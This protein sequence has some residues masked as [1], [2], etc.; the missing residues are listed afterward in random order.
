[1]ESPAKAKTIEKYLGKAYKV[2]PSIGH[3]RDLPESALGVEVGNGFALEYVVNDDKTRVIHDIA[4]AAKKADSVFLATDYD[5]EGEAIAWH[6]AEACDIPADKRRRV[7]FT[8][9]TR[10]AVTEA[11]EHPRDIDI[12]L[13]DAQQARRAIDRLVGYPVSQLLWK[14]IRYGL[15][16]G[17]VQS[18]AL[19]LIVERER[20]IRAFVPVEYWTLA[21]ML[22]T[23]LPARRAESFTA[24]LVQIGD[25]KIPTKIGDSAAD[26]DRRLA[27][28]ADVASVVATLEGARYSV[29]DIRTKEQRR[30]PPPPFIT[31][32]YQQ[33]ASRKLNFGARRAMGVAQ[34]LYEGGYITYMRTDSTSMAAEALAEAAGLIKS[35]FGDRYWNGRY[36][37]HD[38]K[39][40]GAQEAHEC[41]RPTAMSRRRS[42]V[43]AE[44]RAEGGRDAEAMVKV[45][46]LVWKRTVA[47]LM[48]PAVYDQVSVDIAATPRDPA[49]P[50]HL[51]RA[52]GSTLRF[53]GFIRIYLEG[54]DDAEEEEASRLPSLT[55]GQVLSLFGLRPEQHFTQPP[56]RYTEAS[57]VKE[58]EER[59]IGRPS[60]YASI[61]GTLVEEKR[62]YTHLNNRRFVPTDT[63]EV[64]TDFLVRYFGDHFMDF[65]F[66]SDMETHLDGVAEGRFAYRPT[67][68]SFYGPLQDRL[69]KGSEVSK[70]EITTE[71]TDQVCPDCGSPMAVKLG[72]RGKFLGCTNYPDCK[73]TLPMPGQ[74]REAPELLDEK[75]P[76][77]GQ[78][79]AKRRG[80]FGP[81]IGCSTYPECKYIQKKP[82]VSTGHPC[83]KCVAEPCK[84]CK[85][86]KGPGELIERVGKRGK[87]YGCSH[88]P[89]CRHTQNA[90][91]REAPSPEPAPAAAEVPAAASA[92]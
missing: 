21:A 9:I 20:E 10:R 87:F 73:K 14:K 84:T 8:E 60:T 36:K 34:R 30:T 83:P 16:A 25:R 90:D 6:V 54:V 68:E 53:D 38:R 59:G 48:S 17:R 63:G 39:I 2:L 56:P 70:E 89:A 27:V 44:I 40:A 77:C 81:F 78:P 45:Y 64:T 86:A 23:E 41:I 43:E 4:T 66:T 31:S 42:E 65:K 76:D 85:K 82:R 24:L 47:S 88:Y 37:H 12:D 91:P 26:H 22:D 1:V 69:A 29:D 75:C 49:A 58:L 28:E 13:V 15:S 74:E 5:R 19:R 18:P 7:T 62:D 46:D 50:R 33:E 57:L 79:L 71:T 92:G 11:I 72:K 3:V 52:T 61:M 67:V 80:R 32:T 51:F 55:A 35:S